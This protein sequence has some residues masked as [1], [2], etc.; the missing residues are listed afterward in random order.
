MRTIHPFHQIENVGLSHLDEVDSPQSVVRRG[1]S[2]RPPIRAVRAPAEQ[3]G[4][5]Q[6]RLC[7]GFGNMFSLIPLTRPWHF[8]IYF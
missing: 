8:W 1:D 4:L 7:S 2:Q 5:I 6:V 3:G